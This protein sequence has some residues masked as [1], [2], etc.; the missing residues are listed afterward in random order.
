MTVS[1]VGRMTSRPRSMAVM[2]TP[3]ESTLS[4]AAGRRGRL[5]LDDYLQDSS[6]PAQLRDSPQICLHCSA[7]ITYDVR[8]GDRATTRRSSSMTAATS[9]AWKSG[10]RG[11]RPGAPIRGLVRK[12]R[13]RGLRHSGPRR[14]R[15]FL[16][17]LQRDNTNVATLRVDQRRSADLVVL[18]LGLELRTIAGLG[19]HTS[20]RGHRL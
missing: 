1:P 13:R 15:H 9:A 5:V 8:D 18:H 10:Y 2:S 20:C 14:H 11:R 16:Q 6:E 12:W 3:P 17:R 19:Q 7:I 4:E